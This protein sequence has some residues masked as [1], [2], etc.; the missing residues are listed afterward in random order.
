[1]VTSGGVEKVVLLQSWKIQFFLG[2]TSRKFVSRRVAKK[3]YSIVHHQ[4][5]TR[6]ELPVKRWET[7]KARQDKAA[8]I[9]LQTVTA[10]TASVSTFPIRSFKISH[11]D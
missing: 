7:V 1:M 10:V 5:E 6:F 9:T 2:F 11:V 4:I 3:R 8:R